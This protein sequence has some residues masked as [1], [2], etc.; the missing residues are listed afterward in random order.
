MQNMVSTVAS[1]DFSGIGGGVNKLGS[2]GGSYNPYE[3]QM[4]YQQ[5]I[6]RPISVNGPNPPE[7]TSFNIPGAGDYSGGFNKV[8]NPITGQYE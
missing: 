5:M 1:A 3:V 8:F 2:T 4:D 7:L 6:D